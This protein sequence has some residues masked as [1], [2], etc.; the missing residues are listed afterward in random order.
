MN[1]DFNGILTRMLVIFERIRSIEELTTLTVVLFGGMFLFGFLNCILGYRLLRFWVMV[2]GFAIGASVT[3]LLGMSFGVESR[4]TLFIFAFAAGVVV[5]LIAFLI[6]RAGIFL[7]GAGLG[8]LIVTYLIHPTTSALFFLCVL[9]G[10]G[11]G[12]LTLKFEKEILILATSL[13]GGILAGFALAK[14]ISMK[15]VPYGLLFSLGF[16]LFGVL[17]QFLTNRVSDDEEEEEETE[18]LPRQK[19]A[20]DT[21][22][23]NSADDDDIEY[24]PENDTYYNVNEREMN[25]RNFAGNT[26]VPREQTLENMKQNPQ[27]VYRDPRRR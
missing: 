12:I 26:D 27:G 22:F 10:V 5:A 15:E 17:I 16:V 1:F 20:S 9:I 13:A 19:R 2:G 11:V 18:E 23:P 24:D 8:S 25:P 3:M 21:F 6:Y 7:L 4:K 14:L